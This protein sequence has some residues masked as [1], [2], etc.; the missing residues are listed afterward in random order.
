MHRCFAL[1][2]SQSVI[3]VRIPEWAVQVRAAVLGVLLQLM[4]DVTQPQRKEQLKRSGI[5]RAVLFLYKLPEETASNRRLAKQLVESWSRPIF[6]QYSEA[7]HDD[8]RAEDERLQLRAARQQVRTLTPL[9]CALWHHAPACQHCCKQGHARASAHQSALQ[10]RH[11]GSDM[12]HQTAC[13]L[14]V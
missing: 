6:D 14:L 4:V 8:M 12:L 7:R 2:A 1:Q 3:V 13:L 10:P 11:S 9:L 5:G